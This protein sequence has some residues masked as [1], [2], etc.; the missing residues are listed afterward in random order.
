MWPYAASEVTVDRD[1]SP[2]EQIDKAFR[3]AEPMRKAAW[4]KRVR[5]GMGEPGD[6]GGPRPAVV[7]AGDGSRAGMRAKDG[8]RCAQGVRGRASGIETAAQ[9][10]AI[11]ASGHPSWLGLNGRPG[12]RDATARVLAQ[13]LGTATAAVGTAWRGRVV[14][15]PRI[16]GLAARFSEL[17]ESLP[18]A[19]AE[20]A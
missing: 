1:R 20:A 12:L 16:E 14:I 19:C 5:R 4:T 6:M 3:I 15:G 8:P 13:Q 7:R 18:E 17:A 2:A 11:G 10:P 9:D